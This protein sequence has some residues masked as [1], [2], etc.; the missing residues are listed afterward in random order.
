MVNVYGIEEVKN[1]RQ[2]EEKKGMPIQRHNALY[3]NNSIDIDRIGAE[4]DEF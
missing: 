2:V 3:S 4:L 1:Q